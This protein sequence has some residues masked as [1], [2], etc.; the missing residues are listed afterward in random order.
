MAHIPVN[1]SVM[2]QGG[3]AYLKIP[4]KDSQMTGS[5]S[6]NP[7]SPTRSPTPWPSSQTRSDNLILKAINSGAV[8]VHASRLPMTATQLRVML[9]NI[10]STVGLAVGLEGAWSLR[11]DYRLL[12]CLA[13]PKRIT[14]RKTIK[15]IRPGNQAIA[16]C[17][18]NGNLSE[19]GVIIEGEEVNNTPPYGNASEDA[20]MGPVNNVLEDLPMNNNIPKGSNIN[21][22]D[23]V[24]NTPPDGNARED[25]PMGPGNSAL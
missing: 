25:A 13:K 1:G 21:E 18:M 20:S 7:G 3:S 17:R 4:P 16:D 14:Q 19:G 24:N 22:G 11:A 6:G 10:Q 5:S 9:N 15:D 8:K 2:F 23:V 12:E